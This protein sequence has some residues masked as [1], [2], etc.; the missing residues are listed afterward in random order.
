MRRLIASICFML[1]LTVP[2]AAFAYVGPGAGLGLLGALWALVAA[3]ATA[4]S[5]IIAWPFRKALRRRR[6]SR[7]MKPTERRAGR[8]ESDG[9]RDEIGR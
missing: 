9:S 1:A 8:T 3:L 7:G 6:A 5:F 4:L 2:T